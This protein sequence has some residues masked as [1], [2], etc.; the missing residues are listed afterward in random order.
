[1]DIGRNP[2][3][4][5]VGLVGFA[6]AQAV[7]G[8]VRP[9][10]AAS[11]RCSSGHCQRGHPCGCASVDQMK[12]G[13]IAPPAHP[14]ATL[15]RFQF[16]A[17]IMHM[18]S[19]WRDHPVSKLPGRIGAGEQPAPIH[20]HAFT[21]LAVPL[22]CGLRRDQILRPARRAAPAER[23]RSHNRQRSLRRA[24]ALRWSHSQRTRY[25]LRGAR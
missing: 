20:H 1:M 15:A 6:M 19:L 7:A 12:S 11:T 4:L 14:I 8:Q 2:L 9:A 17:P 3:F 24:A 13:S 5:V 23:S 18:N 21:R 10:H 22:R 25:K 16:N